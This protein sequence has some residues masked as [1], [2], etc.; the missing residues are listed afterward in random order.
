MHE[1]TIR[2]ADSQFESF[3]NHLRTLPYVELPSFWEKTSKNG[4]VLENGAGSE[5]PVSTNRHF[6]FT[7]LGVMDETPFDPEDIR[8]NHRI[9]W[10][11]FDEVIEMFKD[12]P[13]ENYIEPHTILHTQ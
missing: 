6:S 13:L 2:V 7:D 12:V 8:K 5:P 10:E 11:R 1:L 4:Q 9:E 3:I